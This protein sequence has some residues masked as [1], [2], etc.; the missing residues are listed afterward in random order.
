MLEFLRKYQRY[1]FILI[2]IMVIASFSF[3]GTFNT[4]T[5]EEVKE[6]RILGRA[7]DGSPLKLSQVQQLSRFLSS[8]RQDFLMRPNE[9]PNFCNDGV[10]RY[11]LLQTGLADLLVSS[12]FDV[13]KGELDPRWEKMKKFR[14]YVHPVFP[15]LSAKAVWQ[16]YR[17]M[18]VREL[19]TI[20]SQEEL[21]PQMF[22]HW[23]RLYLQQSSC[24]PEFL[25][26]VLLY[27]YRQIPGVNED[28]HLHYDDLS[29][30]GFHSLSDWF[31]RD[32]IDLVSEFILNGAKVAEQRGYKVSLEEAKG[33]L[34]R[35]FQASIEALNKMGKK[36]DL[37]FQQHLR[38]LGFDEKSATEAWRSVLLFRR[39]FHGVGDATFVDRLPYRDFASYAREKVVVQ[40]VRLPAVLRLKSF[41]DFIDLQ[42]YLK[43]V[44]KQTDPLA[45][46]TTYLSLDEVEKKFPELVQSTYL[47]KVAKVSKGEVGL[48]ASVKDLWEWQIDEKNWE[49]LKKKFTFLPH[50]MTREDRFQA[51]EKLIE[52]NRSELDRYTRLQC[53]EGHPEWVD[54]SLSS[55]R[56]E[57][58]ALSLSTDW[59]SLNHIEN[60]SRFIGLIEKTVLGDEAAKTLLSQYSDDGETFYRLESVEKISDR[61]LLTLK[62]AK[63]SGAI[64][65]AAER[66]FEG[67]SK[68]SPS[69]SREEVAKKVF[70]D[71]C[72]ALGGEALASSHYPAHRLESYAKEA[73][74]VLQKNPEDT[75]WLQVEGRDPI[76]EQ[77]KFEKETAEIQRTEEEEWMNRAFIMIPKQW[78]SIH[79][80]PDGDIAFYY[81]EVK[82]P[83]P[84]PIFEQLTLGKE[85]LAADAQRYLAEKLLDSAKKKQAIH[86]PVQKDVE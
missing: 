48:R 12:Y 72:K 71:V 35:N 65:R 37:S 74:S 61:H 22:S 18:L 76:T 23:S 75:K 64:S 8:D 13:L 70:G 33:D 67:E 32:F 5:E 38:M 59:V 41:E 6:D 82:K 36:P 46:P 51:L 62:E 3:F 39:Y 54:Q 57:E 55:A 1:F 11:D 40:M 80:D 44:S 10:I 21:T 42:V 81:V 69:L 68:K 66:L 60:P 26:R 53:V 73:L 2:T 20:Q 86:I 25:R 14:P 15:N 47:A 77:F 50:V 49:A 28:P 24:P 9:V 58:K 29:L 17:P 45:I 16:H 84:E 79:V 4:F 19:Q 30:F 43:A 83:H 34:L 31:G 56:M 7:I 78:S 63:S 27:S 52:A 85:T